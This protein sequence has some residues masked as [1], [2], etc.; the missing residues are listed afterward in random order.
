M[1]PP[2]NAPLLPSMTP[3]PPSAPPPGST[4]PADPTF[5]RYT[6]AQASSYLSDRPGYPDALIETILTHHLSPGPA[7]A[8]PRRRLRARHGNPLVR[9]T[10]HACLRR[11]PVRRDD[12]RRARETLHHWHRHSGRRRPRNPDPLRHLDR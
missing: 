11:R 12:R 3:S 10:L 7:P 6:A 9:A 8:P 2:T 1:D 5:R 4:T